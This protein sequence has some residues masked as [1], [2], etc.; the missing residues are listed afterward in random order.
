MAAATF[1]LLIFTEKP[2]SLS[3]NQAIQME[4]AIRENGVISTVGFQ[5]RYDPRYQA[6]QIFLQNKIPFKGLFPSWLFLFKRKFP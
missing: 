5:Q 6:A 4:K 1:G 3:L 2:M